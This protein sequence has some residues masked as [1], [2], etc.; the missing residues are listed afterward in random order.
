MQ[1]QAIDALFALFQAPLAILDRLRP[2]ALTKQIQ[3][4][5]DEVLA[6]LRAANF[7]ARYAQIKAQYFDLKGAVTAGGVEAED[8]AGGFSGA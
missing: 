5:I 4:A 2:A 7:P 3:A 6:V 8:R 1:Q